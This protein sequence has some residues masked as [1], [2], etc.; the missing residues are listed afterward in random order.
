MLLLFLLRA[1]FDHMQIFS[2]VPMIRCALASFLM[3]GFVL[4]YG[5]TPAFAK[6]NVKIGISETPLWDSNPLMLTT[7]KTDIWGSETRAFVD[8]GRMTPDATLNATLAAE[9]N[10]F[11]N[12]SFNSNDFFFRTDLKKNTAL[13]EWSI[14]GRFDY[15][16][17]RTGEIT[18]FGRNTRVGRRLSWQAAPRVAYN[19]SPRA[20]LVLDGSWQENHYDNSVSLTDYR[21]VSL[22]PS[23]VYSLTPLQKA[24]LL[25]RTQHYSSLDGDQDVDSLGPSLGWQY[26]FKPEWSLEL[27]A[28][29]LAS[30]YD[31]YVTAGNDWEYN[32]TYSATLEYLGQRNH[33]SFSVARARQSYANGT[34]SEL[35]S[36]TAENKF[37]INSQWALSMKAL[38]QDAKRSTV[39]M[40]NLDT[41][42]EESVGL[43]YK[44]GERWDFSLSQRFRREELT[45]GLGVAE[46]NIIRAGLTYR[47]GA[48]P[49]LQ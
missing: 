33:T 4:P 46:R 13:W 38:Y 26:R 44:A 24:F 21:T 31:G 5:L 23:V 37:T 18:T 49:Y 41:G 29:F 6:D 19:L 32:P 17:T 2:A 22:S 15:D 3:G 7:G 40:G 16:T 10:Y 8:F 14:N 48:V 9:H 28:G 36:A 43:V 42:Y 30:K 12:S 27:F 39:S 35:I 20:Q 25:F 11:N 47:L 1:F 34:E 45:N